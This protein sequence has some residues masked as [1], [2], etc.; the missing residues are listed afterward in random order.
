MD[1]WESNPSVHEIIATSEWRDSAVHTSKTR[2]LFLGN[3]LVAQY[4]RTYSLKPNYQVANIAGHMV[5]YKDSEAEAQQACERILYR[6][7]ERL[8]GR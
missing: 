2:L 5:E 1:N 3:V 7:T 8:Q 4:E 6:F